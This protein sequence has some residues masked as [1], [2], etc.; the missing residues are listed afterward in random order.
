MV[1]R[2]D[3]IGNASG[4]KERP[5]ALRSHLNAAASELLVQAKL[6]SLGYDVWV[7]LVDW[8]HDLMAN[9]KTVQVK[10]S[11]GSE[12]GRGGS[13][14]YTFAFKRKNISDIT[15]L[16]GISGDQWWVVP[17]GELPV[18]A[19]I[20][21]SGVGNNRDGIG[22]P[23]VYDYDQWLDAWHVFEEGY[24]SFTG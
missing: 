7:P 15:V 23:A 24:G 17:S 19:A 20:A 22:R 11:F 12:N 4:H 5:P 21:V 9:G 16:H 6:L 14:Q 18:K 8:G 10:S 1:T 13:F 2:M 3:T